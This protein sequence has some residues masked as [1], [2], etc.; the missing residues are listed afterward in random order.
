MGTDP[1]NFFGEKSSQHFSFPKLHAHNYATAIVASVLGTVLA[2][3]SAPNFFDILREQVTGA[4]PE[5]WK[6]IS[7]GVPA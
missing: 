4:V 6:P 5:N 7:V 3:H 2:H 1:V